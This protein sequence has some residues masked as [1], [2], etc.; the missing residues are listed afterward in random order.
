MSRERVADLGH[1]GFAD[2]GSGMVH[3]CG[4]IAWGRR[5]GLLN[6]VIYSPPKETIKAAR[7]KHQCLK[8]MYTVKLS[9][10]QGYQYKAF[11]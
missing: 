5:V 6:R 2:K 8:T 1:V 9:I 11:A 3:F 10:R 7:N 4:L